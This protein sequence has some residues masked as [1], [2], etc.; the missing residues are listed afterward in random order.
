M[1]S[2]AGTHFDKPVIENPNHISLRP[3][4]MILNHPVITFTDSLTHQGSRQNLIGTK[5]FTSDDYKKRNSH[6]GKRIRDVGKEMS[7]TS[8]S[9]LQVT[10]KTPPTFITSA[11]TDKAV[12][13]GNSLVFVT[14][15]QQNNVPV[16]V[17][18]Y[19]KR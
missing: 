12:P 2:T 3:D 19:E 11:L 18:F 10:Y 6:Q 13:V 17:F 15:L 16:E 1:A 14:A 7:S 5:F 4:F 9:Q 8:L